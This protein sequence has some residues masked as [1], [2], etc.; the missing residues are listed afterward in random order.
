MLSCQ[1]LQGCRMSAVDSILSDCSSVHQKKAAV[2]IAEH[3]ESVLLLELLQ[4]SLQSLQYHQ[5]GCC[6]QLSQ[7]GM[8]K[9][10]SVLQW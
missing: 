9:K 1:H 7:A 2:H 5:L 4:L 6:R 10:S 3:F 8:K